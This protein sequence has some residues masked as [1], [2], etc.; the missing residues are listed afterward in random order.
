MKTAV[1]YELKAPRKIFHAA[2]ALI[3]V[4]WL[5]GELPLESAR[6]AA[7]TALALLL[8]FDWSRQRTIRG[9]ALAERF[10]GR[11]LVSRDGL[12]LN[13]STWYAVA[14]TLLFIV[15]TGDGEREQVLIGLPI[16]YLALGDPAAAIIGKRVGRLPLPW[17]SGSWPGSL[18]CLAVCLTSGAIVIAA[19]AHP[20]LGWNAVILSS[21]AATLAESLP[22]PFDDNLT[23]PLAAA[24]VLQI[25]L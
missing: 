2:T 18:A 6:I 15:A 17:G 11:L 16:L 1:G 23:L 13:S 10:C 14:L 25:C 12:G 7:V 20:L 21:V 3:G 8:A 19:G 9:K 22:G 5:A 4:A 24:A